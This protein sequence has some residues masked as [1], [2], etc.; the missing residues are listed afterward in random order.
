MNMRCGMTL[1]QIDR[2]NYFRGLLFLISIDG[3]EINKNKKL[4]YSLASVL[5]FNHYFIDQEIKDF[6][7][8]NE[9]NIT[10]PKFSNHIL[11]EAFLKD[12]IKIAFIDKALHISE[13]NWLVTFTQINQLSKQWFF[14]ELENFLENYESNESIHFELQ[15]Y[16]QA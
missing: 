12:G 13:L 2:S 11:A 16:I 6:I 1:N 3:K 15:N 14:L 8:T 7:E 5:G 4:L 9:V 10:P